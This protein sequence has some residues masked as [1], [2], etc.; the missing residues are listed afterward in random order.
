MQIFFENIRLLLEHARVK[1]IK[2][3]YTFPPTNNYGTDHTIHDVTK[4]LGRSRPILMRVVSIDQLFSI[5]YPPYGHADGN[6]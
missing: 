6:G 5:K 3:G 2:T 4:E 1:V